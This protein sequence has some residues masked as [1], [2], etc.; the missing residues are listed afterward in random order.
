MSRL[1]RFLFFWLV[2]RPVVLLGLGLNVRHRERLP[3]EGPAVL[4]AN[5]NSHLDTMVLMT[6]L[7]SRLLPRVRPVAAADYFLRN[8]LIAWFALEVI[9]IL[10]IERGGRAP[11]TDPLA[12]VSAALARGEIVIL[13]PEGS[14]GEPER[15]AEFKSGVA[16]LALRCPEVPVIPLFLHGLGK[17]LPKGAFFPVP[18]FCDV[19]VGEPLPPA[20][21]KDTYLQELKSRMQALAGEG[22]FS[23]WE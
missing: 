18:F 22:Q 21:D 2:V 5:H 15:L 19:F 17:A 20:T 8:R 11:G 6:L 16:R 4:V 3:R 23:V 12:G 13:F 7:P 9:G 14:R 1:P 10:P